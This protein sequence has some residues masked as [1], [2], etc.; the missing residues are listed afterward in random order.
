MRPISRYKALKK[1]GD[2]VDDPYQEATVE[3]L[4]QLYESLLNYD[5]KPRSRIFKFFSRQ[6]AFDRIPKGIYI[7]GDVGR[8]K[9]MLMDLLFDIVPLTKKRRVHFHSFMSDVH[10]RINAFR[11]R[12][13]EDRDGNDPIPSVAKAL[14]SDAW[15]LCFDEFEVRDV[16]DAMIVGRLFSQI[17]SQG[18]VI[19][20]TSNR[21][22][23]DLYKGG[24]N[25][26]LFVPFIELMK[27]Q[28]EI[29]YLEGRKDHR[30]VRLRGMPV[31]HYPL[32]SESQ[33]ALDSTFLE[34]S[35]GDPG[36]PDQVEIMGRIIDVRKQAHGTACF[37]FADLCI[38]PLAAN[39]YIA[40]AERYQTL[41]VSGIP[42]L[43]E[44][45]R[46]EARRLVLLIDVLYDNKVKL[47]ASAQTPVAEIYSSLHV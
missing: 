15:L 29:I 2:L 40:I 3:K 1:A 22:P 37:S 21:A 13:S 14:A 16:A 42:R 36:T 24:L 28:L 26:Q 34:L 5:L 20:A 39:D 32:N 46:N 10:K 8:G 47:V 30:L 17:F 41:I 38:E 27:Q 45:K 44:S 7:H 9:S 33:A 4:D 12:S 31:Y 11:K 19:V 43:D 18:V 23:D 25:R 6:P 35:D